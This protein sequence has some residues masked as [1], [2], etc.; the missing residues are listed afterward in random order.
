MDLNDLREHLDG[1]LDKIEDKLNNHLERISKSETSI[2][3]LKGHLKLSLSLLLAALSG[4]AGAI[5]QYV[6]K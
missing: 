4:M 2:E 6:V 5:Y 1:R 3:W